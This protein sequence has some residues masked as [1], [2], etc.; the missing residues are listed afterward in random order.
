MSDYKGAWKLTE[1][2][3]E[4][5]KETRDSDLLEMR[6]NEIIKFISVMLYL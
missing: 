5:F 6:P 1:K 3:L 2:F 4:E